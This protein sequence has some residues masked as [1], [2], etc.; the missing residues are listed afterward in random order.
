MNRIAL[1]IKNRLSL[2]QPQTDS[3]EILAELAEKLE[4]KKEINI[5]KELNKVRELY[6]TCS[7]FERK[8]PSLCFALATGVGKTRLMG[9]FIAYL[10]LKKGIK[11][12][13]VLAPNLTIY[14]KLTDDLENTNSPKY[15]FRGIAE[16]V[17]NAPRIITGDNYE[18][19]ASGQ[20]RVGD[21]NQ[22]I[23]INIFNISKINSETRGGKEPRI[24]R[25]R[26]TLGESYFKY[27]SNLNDLVLIMDE[28]HHYRADRGMEVLNELNPILGLEL[29]ATPQIEKNQKT[30]KFNNVVY[31]YPLG[32]AMKDGFVK[33]PSVATR[34]DFNAD[35]YKDSL[36]ELD[37]IKL[38]DGIRIHEKTKVDLEIYSR[39]NNL[40]RVKPFVLVVAKETKHAAWIKELISAPSFF[41]GYYADKVM[42]IHSKQSGSEKDE[43]VEK[44]ISLEDPNNKIEIVIHVNMLKEGWDV[45]NL[46]T[47]IPLRTSAS[48]TLTE[49]TIGRGLRLPYG[50]RVGDIA[51]DKLTIIAHDNFQKIVEAA[52]KPDSIINKEQ[53]VFINENDLEETKEVIVSVPAIKKQYAE[54]KK[55]I[56]ISEIPE[57]EKEEKIINIDIKEAIYDV[58]PELQNVN[59]IE[60][61]KSEEVG[62]MVADRVREKLASEKQQSFFQDEIIDKIKDNYQAVVEEK[63]KREIKIPRIS[64]VPSGSFSAGFN[65]FDLNTSMGSLNLQPV[66]EEIIEKILARKEESIITHK[67]RM[68]REMDKPENLIIS[69]LINFNEID[70][71]EHSDLLY[72]LS[73]QAITHF[74]SYLN[75]DEV[76]NVVL[77]HKK[78]IAKYIYSQMKEYF[79]MDVTSF[80]AYVTKNFTEIKDHNMAKISTDNIHHHTET[81][82]PTRTIPSKIFNG[83]NKCCHDML[84]FDSKS[85]KDFATMLEDEDFVDKWLKPAPKQFKIWWGHDHKSYEPDFVV[86]TISSIHLIEIKARKDMENK[87]VLE[88]AKAAVQFCR[89]ATEHNL[90]HGEKEWKYSI[91]PH[92]RVQAQ[93]SF[94]NLVK[95]WKIK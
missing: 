38:E 59:S 53:I 46:Y 62:N 15:V 33:E 68:S 9:A 40:R 74:F 21:N 27:L 70:Y 31:D 90:K 12:F 69:E 25:L 48:S 23:N 67:G 10:N 47:I 77:Y 24:K 85:E 71:D 6:P 80:E 78:E 37:R 35:N 92:D 3:L 86:E 7:D 18:Y 54:E 17:H 49:Q 34:R 83:F 36:E 61:L 28:S 57:K 41:K 20:M 16:F 52:N 87:D 26:E 56:L 39:D 14:N 95:Q 93:M 4:L 50:K 8:F 65:D 44:L 1:N 22:K 42:E 79:Y 60:E 82:E 75:E 55:Q 43:N 45:T 13:F 11:N 64:V 88:K 84:K 73:G 89:Y 66:S 72:K 5:E 29:T 19:E 63:I 94:E 30:I 81:I 76:E 32:R 91:I 2:R 51:V 58:I